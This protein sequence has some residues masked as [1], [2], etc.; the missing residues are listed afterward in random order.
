M[1]EKVTVQMKGQTFNG[2]DLISVIN[3]LTGFKK[4][5]ESSRIHK[6]ITVWLFRELVSG[7]V[8]TAIKVRLTL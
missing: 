8:L 5:C 2:Q 1:T 3:I 6:G 4:P 7:P